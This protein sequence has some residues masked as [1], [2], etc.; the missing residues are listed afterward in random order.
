VPAVGVELALAAEICRV[1]GSMLN[2]KNLEILSL[3][4]VLLVAVSI[5][6]LKVIETLVIPGAVAL[7]IMPDKFGL[8]IGDCCPGLR[9]TCC[10]LHDPVLA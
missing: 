4:G 1:P 2:A 7:Y 6:Y 9:V 10:D 5:P 8:S 3:T